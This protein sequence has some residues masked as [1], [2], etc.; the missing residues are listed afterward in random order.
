MDRL[1]DTTVA[2]LKE[3]MKEYPIRQ[4]ALLPALY[5]VQAEEGNYLTK[6]HLTHIAAVMGL[7]KSLIYEVVTFYMLFYLEPRGKHTIRLCRNLCCFVRGSDELLDHLEG[8]LGIKA[9]ETTPDGLFSLELSE[10]L[11]ACERAPMIMINEKTFGP[12]KNEDLKPL[13]DQYR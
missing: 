11:A 3:L 2:K 9:G 10:C 1:K 12:L 13:L 8:I 6:D 7:P 4:G 5:M